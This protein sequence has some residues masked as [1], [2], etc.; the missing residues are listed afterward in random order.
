MTRGGTC[1]DPFGGWH[2]ENS[3]IRKGASIMTGVAAMALPFAAVFSGLRFPSVRKGLG[4]CGKMVCCGWRARAGDPSS[5]CS[6]RYQ[7]SHPP[8]SEAIGRSSRR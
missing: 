5:P 1:N 7:S 3:I 8:G 6:A 2:D 4:A